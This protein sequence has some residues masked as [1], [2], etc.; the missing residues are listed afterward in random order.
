MDDKP[1]RRLP[2]IHLST[3]VILTVVAGLIL[4]LNFV[5]DIAIN[6]T[7]YSEIIGVKGCGFPCFTYVYVPERLAGRN[8]NGEH[9]GWQPGGVIL[10]VIFAS[11]ILL[12]TMGVCEHFIRRSEAVSEKD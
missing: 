6:G 9:G 8:L 11:F 2:Q 10:N 3:G 5:R 7:D 1:T 4:A 12:S